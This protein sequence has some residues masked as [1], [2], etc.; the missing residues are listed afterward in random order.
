MQVSLFTTCLT[1]SYYPQAALATVRLLQHLG[2]TVDCPTAQT[3]CGQPQF[4]NG[5]HDQARSLARHFIDTFQHAPAIVSPSASCT[6]MIRDYYEQLFAHDAAYLPRARDII[7]KTFEITE[8]ITTV[9]LPDLAALTPRST[10]RI[11]YHYSCHSRGLNLSPDV[12]INLIKSIEGI[13]Y[14]PL[15]KMDQCCGFGGTFAVKLPDVS[16]AL[17]ADKVACIRNTNADTV[18][19]NDGGCTLNIAGACRRQRLPV[20]FVHVAQLLAEALGLM[21]HTSEA[22]R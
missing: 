8:F 2:C 3:C 15:E 14:V 5:L 1:D 13:D 16:A 10:G 7:A 18:V 12:T 4:N 17:V 9:L 6:A 21:D 11:T 22:H 20:R 19:V